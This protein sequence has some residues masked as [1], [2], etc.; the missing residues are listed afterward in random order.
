[1]DCD[2]AA[3]SL[4]RGRLPLLAMG[5]GVWAG[6][7]RFIKPDL[8]LIDAYEFRI[9][10]DFPEDDLGGVTYRQSSAYR[11]D[12]GAARE[13]MFEGRLAGDRLIFDNG[14][15]AGQLWEVDE[16]TIYL[17]FRFSDMPGVEVF[18]MIQPL[19]GGDTRARTWH[20]L[21]HGELYQIT[22]VEECRV[23]R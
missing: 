5:E 22:L 17:R 11:W 8:T 21:R 13:V 20:W 15:I 1:M 3:K 9:E 4:I 2:I 12:D 10:V 16:A 19:P 14:R 18:E 6:R 7:Y 23:G